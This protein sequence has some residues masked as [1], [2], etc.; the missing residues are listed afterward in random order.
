MNR[1]KK[2][3][4]YI[5]H[6]W[7]G[8][9]EK[10]TLDLAKN[11]DKDYIIYIL[12]PDN[13]G[14]RLEIYDDEIRQS[15]F[16][17][18]GYKWNQKEC[19]SE[20]Y[21]K[22]LG[23]ILK[24][25]EINI[26]SIHHLI[27]HT[28]DIFHVAR[29][30]QIPLVFTVSD[31]YSVCPR[32]NLIDELSYC[33]ERNNIER[34][35]QCMISFGLS[36]DFISEWRKEFNLIFD[37][38]DVII[39]L[40]KSMINILNKYYKIDKTKIRIIEPGNDQ[41]AI[42]YG[43]IRQKDNDLQLSET[44]NIAYIGVLC[45]HK[46]ERV[47]YELSQSKYDK[48]IKWFLIGYSGKATQPGYYPEDNAYVTGK[49]E[50]QK[51]LI[52]TLVSKNIHLSILP[53]QCPE[54]YSFVL[55]ES[56][57]AGIP[58]I[59][60]KIGALGDRV[61][62]SKCGWVV[63]P[64]ADSFKKMIDQILSNPD[65]YYLIKSR[66]KNLKLKNL[67]EF[68]GDYRKVYEGL[69]VALDRDED[70]MARAEMLEKELAETSSK[71]MNALNQIENMNKQNANLRFQIQN[72]RRTILWQMMMAMIKY[73]SNI[74]ERFLPRGSRRRNAYDLAIEC[75]RILVNDGKDMVWCKSKQYF[76]MRKY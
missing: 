68:A 69:S 42:E 72:I 14:Y 8:G 70:R 5:S 27:G 48:N 66:I 2:R 64:D 58:P 22:L 24:L 43:K 4:L 10:Y 29:D 31:F 35:S 12:K 74:I 53:A 38:C 46:G 21:K 51:D 16:F 28:L 63:S 45:S 20:E 56:W 54:T 40:N 23:K 59:V 15:I 67:E 65:D 41:S 11:L 25:F 18:I 26:I 32:I 13:Y 76:K 55:T 52:S 44:I 61:E 1:N 71:Y 60:S 75:G 9:T 47:F 6:N 57:M 37:L 73:R 34:C 50:D 30:F 17:N 7:G 62:S 36:A 39:V 19:F 49:Y 33:H 3:I